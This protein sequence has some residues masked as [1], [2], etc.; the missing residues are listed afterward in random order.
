MFRED[1]DDRAANSTGLILSPDAAH[2]G[3]QDIG[4]QA[5]GPAVAFTILAGTVVSLRW[6][7]RSR[8][9]QCVGSDDYVILLSLV[10][11]V[12]FNRST[13]PPLTTKQTLSIAMTGVIGAEV[14]EGVGS[15]SVRTTDSSIAKLIIAS[16]NLWILTVN[17]TKAS[18]LIQY[19]RIFTSRT[20]RL[21]CYILIVLLLP[22][23]CWAIFAGTFLCSPTAKLW[24]PSLPGHCLSSQTYWISVA[25]VDIGL[26]FLVLL[27]PLPSITSL[28]L[29][30]KQKVVLVLV[31]TL[32][33]F[34]CIVS[35]VR[36][37]T[38]VVTS[39]DGDFVASGVWAIIWSAVE[40]NVGII[41]ASLFALKPLAA[42]LFPKLMEEREPP[43]HSMRLA[44]VEEGDGGWKQGNSSEATLAYPATPTTT[45]KSSVLKRYNSPGNLSGLG[46]GGIPPHVLDTVDDDD[47]DTATVFERPSPTAQ[48]PD[49]ERLSLFDMLQEGE[50]QARERAGRRNSLFVEH[51]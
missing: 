14:H 31:F 18:I 8:L 6:Y 19:L 34:V 27:L 33:F 50:E 13:S 4:W 37:A 28:R 47:D 15:Y 40:A 17:I 1:I 36:L 45:T 35:V 11:D 9:A 7:T 12:N 43:R 30:D 51:V 38:V 22:A 21:L 24:Q 39:N 16:N 10:C 49:R 2:F 41:C 42:K 5:L 25:S 3:A 29:P 26:D 23:V 20:P 44:I 46:N 48:Q 32:G